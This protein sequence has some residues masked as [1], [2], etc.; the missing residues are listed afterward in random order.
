MCGD[1]C[2][3]ENL[4][5]FLCPPDATYNPQKQS[6]LCSFSLVIRWMKHQSLVSH[7]ICFMLLNICIVRERSTETSKVLS[8]FIM[9][10]AFIIKCV[11]TF[12]VS[13]QL[14]IFYWPRMAMLRCFFLAFF[15]IT[16]KSSIWDSARI[17][18]STCFSLCIRWRTLV[19]LHN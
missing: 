2:T 17:G 3:V 7:V 11:L 14:L 9:S 1:A 18:S 15:F 19:C 5:L 8:V 13:L 12:F 6:L 4:V 16:V 10:S